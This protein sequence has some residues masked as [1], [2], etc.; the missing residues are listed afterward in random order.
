MRIRDFMSTPTMTISPTASVIEARDLM[1]QRQIRHLPVL[2][3][4]RVMGIITDRDIRTVLPSPATSLA[5]REITYLLAKLTVDEVMARAVITVAPDTPVTE[6]ISHILEHTIGALPVIE[7][8]QVVGM[9][10][11][12]NI[13][14]AFVRS[15]GAL[16]IA[17]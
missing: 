2:N 17:A 7:A 12:T 4:E 6:A 16:P 15:Q 9:L 8:Q 13:L 3:S 10:T 5:A 14:R 11:R 1:R